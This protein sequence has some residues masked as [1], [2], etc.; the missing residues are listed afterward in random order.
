VSL[1][2]SP[3]SQIALITHLTDDGQFARVDCIIAAFVHVLQGGRKTW[4]C[5]IQ[6]TLANYTLANCAPPPNAQKLH[7]PTEATGK[8]ARPLEF[9][10]FAN[11]ELLGRFV[12]AYWSGFSVEGVMDATRL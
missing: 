6:S 2:Y 8:F 7:F 1:A 12:R 9:A 4:G 11:S 5:V 10:P 3:P